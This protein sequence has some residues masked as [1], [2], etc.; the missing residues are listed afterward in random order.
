MIFVS[1]DNLFSYISALHTEKYPTFYFK[2][3]SI[4]TVF[5]S[6]YNV[7]EIKAMKIII[8]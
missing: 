2:S 3:R 1:Y 7:G 4:Y 6:E 5:Y 8:L